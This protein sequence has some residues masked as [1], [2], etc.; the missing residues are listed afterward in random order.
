MNVGGVIESPSTRSRTIAIVLT[1]IVVALG[2]AYY[3]SQLHTVRRVKVHNH[4]AAAFKPE[5]SDTSKSVAIYIFMDRNATFRPDLR[6]KFWERQISP[7]ELHFTINYLADGLLNVNGIQ[8]MIPSV[9]QLEK[10]DCDPGYCYRNVESWSHFI[11]NQGTRRWYFKAS[12]DSFINPGNLLNLVEEIEKTVNPAADAF[13]Q[14]TI[15]EIHGYA[16]PDGVTG[17][18]ISNAAVRALFH[19]AEHFTFGC[20]KLGENAGMAEMIQNFQLEVDQFISPYFVADW[21]NETLDILTDETHPQNFYQCPSKQ[22]RYAD[23]VDAPFDDPKDLV[24]TRM[25]FAPMDHVE[26]LLTDFNP[27]LRIGYTGDDTPVFC[28]GH[29][30]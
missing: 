6:G 24:A 30:D 25:P 21:P 19:H 16:V 13:F 29:E 11:K 3:V 8:P 28:F 23:K 12:Q 1:I 26:T 27:D 14:Y 20:D 4:R 15:D 22:Y 5:W 9:C 7:T 18:L 17:W 10:G 2:S